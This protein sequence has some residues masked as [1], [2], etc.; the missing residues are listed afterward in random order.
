MSVAVL[1]ITLPPRGLPRSAARPF[2]KLDNREVFM[3]C[4]E[5]YANREQVTQRI[6]VFHPD[7]LA[8]VQQKFAA[9]LGF[10]GVKVTAA[11]PDW[12][13]AVARGLEK[14]DPEI[15]T[16]IVHDASR[17]LVPF[18]TIDALESHLSSAAGVAPTLS[19]SGSLYRAPAGKLVDPVAIADLVEVQSP[20]AFR[21]DALDKAYA[22]REANPTLDD[23]GL[24]R[25][26]G[27]KIASVPGNRINLRVDSEETQKLAADWLKHLPRPKSK[28]SFNPFGEAEW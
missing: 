14:L 6:A 18:T 5:M 1:F 8:T 2:A 21:R 4:I 24:I 28:A 13:A 12:P 20:Q 7:D 25:A 9:H 19:V 3:R 27:E 15:K 10:Q 22:A 17:P 23:L 11:G 16:V 26:L